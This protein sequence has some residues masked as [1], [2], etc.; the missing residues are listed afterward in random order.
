M[1][2]ANET[3]KVAQT[4]QIIATQFKRLFDRKSIQQISVKEI[5]KCSMISRSG[6]YLHFQDKYALFKY[7]LEQ[8][9]NLW[10]ESIKTYSVKDFIFFMFDSIFEDRNFYYNAFI[11]EPT[12]ELHNIVQDSYCELFR[13][14]FV[15]GQTAGM[16]IPQP[17]SVISN[18]YAGAVLSIIELWL[19]KEPAITKDEIANCLIA[20][21]PSWMI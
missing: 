15:N 8:K 6:F 20:L 16:N 11:R 21:M 18:F 4:K 13:Q 3:A 19:Y 12:S 5:C 14:C 9:L 2:T 1:N 7:C 17:V 10:N